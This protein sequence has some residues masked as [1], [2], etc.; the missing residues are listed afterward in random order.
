MSDRYLYRKTGFVKLIT[1]FGFWTKT[2]VIWLNLTSLGVLDVGWYGV[3]NI[4][5]LVFCTKTG[6]VWLDLNKLLFIHKAAI[7]TTIYN[8]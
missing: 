2:G 5:V 8:K 3:K 1:F 7:L 4:F 6:I